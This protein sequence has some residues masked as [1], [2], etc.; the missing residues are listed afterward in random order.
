MISQINIRNFK[1]FRDLSVN[2]ERFTMLVGENGSGKSSFMQS[3]D[4]LC[5]TFRSQTFRTQPGRLAKE[6]T[7]NQSCLDKVE[8]SCEFLGTHFRY[9][10]STGEEFARKTV[11]LTWRIWEKWQQIHGRLPNPV[12]LRL[13]PNEIRNSDQIHADTAA[14]KL[15]NPD[16][17]LN[18]QSYLHN[19]IPAVHQ[20]RHTP[21]NE[22]LF[23]TIMGKE[24]K[25]HQVS[26]G[27]I[28]SLDILKAIYGVN[29]PSIFLI[30]NLDWLPHCKKMVRLCANPSTNIQSLKS[31]KT[32]FTPEKCGVY[33]E[34]NGFL[35]E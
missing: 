9:C 4:L 27:V 15:A 13:D 18:L 32:S 3:V 24:L 8:L 16:R 11:P 10:N 7:N 20:L 30:D 2:L 5:Q 22:L 21:Q 35:N 31:G 26:D 1:C 17:W 29:E 12:W 25:V 33:S 19:I 34:K 6:Y 23:D 28:V 14:I